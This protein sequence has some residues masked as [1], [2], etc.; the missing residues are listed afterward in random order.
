MLGAVVGLLVIG[1]A[2]VTFLVYTRYGEKHVG[3]QRHWSKTDE[4]FK[5]PTTGRM[6]RVWLDGTDGSRHYLPD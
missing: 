1:V 6:M 5:D 4:V 2:V 3:P